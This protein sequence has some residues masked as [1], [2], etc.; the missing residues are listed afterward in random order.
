MDVTVYGPLRSAT[1]EK[2][3]AVDVDPETVGDVVAAF[4]AQHPRIRSQLYTDDGDLRPS[5]RVMVDGE[6]ADPADACPADA[7][8]VLFPAMQGGCW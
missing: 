2:T 4:A 1:G 6:R 3:V 7:A 8:V 5:V